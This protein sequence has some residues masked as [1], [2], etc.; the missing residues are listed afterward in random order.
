[1]MIDVL[2]F[3]SSVVESKPC[4]T[5]DYITTVAKSVD[6]QVDWSFQRSLHRVFSPH[7][8]AD[9]IYNFITKNTLFG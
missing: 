4:P 7:H 3:N 5:T 8:G 9:H 2:D 1:M 6:I